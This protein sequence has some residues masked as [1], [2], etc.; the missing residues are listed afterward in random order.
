MANS[1]R[2]RY[3]ETNPIMMST[4]AGFSV[5]IGDLVYLDSGAAKS[6]S[7]QADQG[8][9]AANQ[10]ALHDQFLGVAMQASPSASSDAIRVATSGVFEFNCASATFEMGDLLGA[11]EEGTGTVLENQQL[12][13]VVTPNLAV[14]RCTK[15]VN[16]AGAKVLVD[17]VS[18]ILRGG[19]QAAA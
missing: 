13:G 9:L 19:P 17:I 15:R 7:A 16:P 8:S 1:M 5:K 2:W 18:T 12:I 6:A 14:G 11:K 3:G 10:E 4:A